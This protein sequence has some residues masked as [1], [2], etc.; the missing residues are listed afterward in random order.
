MPSALLEPSNTYA[1][2]V[3]GDRPTMFLHDWQDETG[4][5]HVKRRG[6]AGIAETAL[7]NG[8]VAY[9]FNGRNWLEIS[10]GGD[11]S[12][13]IT[14]TFTLEAWVRPD[15]LDFQ[16]GER[17][18][19]YVYVLGKGKPWEYAMRMYSTA[20]PTESTN[21]RNRVSFYGWSPSGGEGSGAYFQDALVAGEWLHV[22]CVFDL[23]PSDT[24]PLGFVEIWRDGTKRQRVSMTQFNTVMK[25]G[26]APLRV[27]TRDMKSFFEGAV[28]NVAVY[29]YVLSEDTIKRHGELMRNANG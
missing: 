23:N 19:G 13:A 22:V 29:D 4:N 27:G 3:M 17:N 5:H 26:D 14:K 6:Q 18:T 12:P 25:A 15:V 2:A 16:Y 8:D 20:T 24:Y 11:L 21:R 7:P 10:D 28:G 1:D 9:Q